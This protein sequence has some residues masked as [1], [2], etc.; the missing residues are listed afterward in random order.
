MEALPG[1]ESNGV[2]VGPS[3]CEDAPMSERQPPAPPSTQTCDEPEIESL[4]LAVPEKPQG[5]QTLDLL[6]GS[7]EQAYRLG[8]SYSTTLFVHLCRSRGLLPY[9]HR[10]QH[11]GT[12]C[13]RAS[14]SEH[15]ALWTQFLALRRELG[16][17][18]YEVTL[19]FVKQT[20]APSKR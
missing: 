11:S 2:A 3:A 9:R 5:E 16:S 14:L 13:V 17:R 15:D 8:D 10:R 18:L 20:V 4:Q 7:F 1:W 6:G 12:I 19:N